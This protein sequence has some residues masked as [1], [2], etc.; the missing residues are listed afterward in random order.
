[1]ALEFFAQVNKDGDVGVPRSND[2]IFVGSAADFRTLARWVQ[3]GVEAGSRKPTLLAL[4]KKI[5]TAAPTAHHLRF[6][7]NECQHLM[8]ALERKK[9][10]KSKSPAA[11]SLLNKL[12]NCLQV[13]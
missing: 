1:M 13:Y 8:D 11:S 5:E 7:A 10:S 4:A 2:Y 3:N 9:A 6:N 12:A